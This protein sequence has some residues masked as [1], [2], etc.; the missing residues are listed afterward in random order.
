MVS[1]LFKRSLNRRGLYIYTD[2]LLRE[3]DVFSTTLLYFSPYLQYGI[4]IIIA[5]GGMHRR[6]LVYIFHRSCYPFSFQYEDDQINGSC[7][8]Y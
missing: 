8:V 6:E 3:C 2:F 5:S 1:L 4:C 7:R